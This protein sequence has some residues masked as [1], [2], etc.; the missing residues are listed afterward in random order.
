VGAPDGV[1]RLGGRAGRGVG[2]GSGPA[3]KHAGRDVAKL[4]EPA[5][6]GYGD[7]TGTRQLDAVVGGRVVAGGEHRGGQPQ[8]SG[9]VGHQVGGSEPDVDHVDALRGHAVHEGVDQHRRGRPHV[10]PDHHRL[11]VL[12]EHRRRG[13]TERASDTLVQFSVD[14]A[15]DVVGLD[16]PVEH[17]GRGSGHED[18]CT[19][20]REGP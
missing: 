1:A 3:G 4:G 6:D 16:D 10:A 9:G 7:G 11:V 15:P 12:D 18:S 14:Q 5:G 2:V 20:R 13:D 19:V 17:V 8:L